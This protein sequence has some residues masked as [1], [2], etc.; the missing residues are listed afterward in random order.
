M[1]ASLPQL[2][3]PGWSLS[4]GPPLEFRLVREPVELEALAPA[5][6]ALLRAS[7]S[8]EPMLGPDW[9]LP[10]WSV[11]GAGRELRVG[12]FHEGER[13]VGLAPLCV[14]R[15]WHRPGIPLWRLEFLGADVDEGD[16]V[17]S[18]YLNLVAAVGQEE[19]IA[20]AFAREV[21][22]GSFGHWHELVLG[23]LDGEGPMPA[24]LLEAFAA[25]GHAGERQVT[26]ES[27][28]LQLPD[29][30]DTYLRQCLNKDKRRHLQ[31]ALR[32]FEAWA[33]SDWKVEHVRGP[34]DLMHGRGILHALHNH[35]WQAGDDC[36]GAFQKPRFVS[37]HDEVM[38]R[39]LERGQLEL[40]WLAVRDKPVAVHYQ[41]V[42]NRK[43]YYYQCGRS[44][45]VPHRVKPGI[46]LLAQAIRRAIEQGLR[47][48]DFLGGDA[49][50]KRELSRTRRPL[51][52]LR[53]SQGGPR[54][55]LRRGADA[56]CA[57][58]RQLRR[59]LRP[60]PTVATVNQ[61]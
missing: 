12:L 31:Q 55:W 35:R 41:I 57:W 5:W 25:R 45:D 38:P 56:A 1:Q 52:Q 3:V 10:W 54:E 4:A 39:L 59:R 61:D 23:A 8:D 43:V 28:Y 11:Y 51:V 20:H 30:W 21:L 40:F 34:A 36:G 13:L 26:T 33:G 32:G 29:S 47:E 6:Q 24:L 2:A 42:A 60:V 53:F 15:R 17:C 22:R 50:Y 46:F 37:F 58:A 14:R 18:E 44:L 49:Q 9:L 7:L 48:F 27:P 16:G 19:R